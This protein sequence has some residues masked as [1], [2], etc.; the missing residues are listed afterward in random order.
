MLCGSDL[1]QWLMMDKT[2]QY[3]ITG[4]PLSIYDKLIIRLVGQ[5]K[6][7]VIQEEGWGGALPLFAKH[8]YNHGYYFVFPQGQYDALYC[9]ECYKESM[10]KL[11]NVNGYE[12]LKETYNGNSYVW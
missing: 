11:S 5:L 1:Y 7:G 2:K 12:Y 3:D 9:K 8:C 10:L 6:I 4:R